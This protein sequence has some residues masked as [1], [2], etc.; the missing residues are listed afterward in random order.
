MAFATFVQRL[1]RGSTDEGPLNGFVAGVI[2]RRQTHKEDDTSLQCMVRTIALLLWALWVRERAAL[3]QSLLLNEAVKS[4][5]VTEQVAICALQLYVLAPF[6]NGSHDLVG[7]QLT[8]LEAAIAR[9]GHSNGATATTIA[10][11][12]SWGFTSDRLGA[13]HLKRLKAIRAALQSRRYVWHESEAPIEFDEL[14]RLVELRRYE[15]TR[16]VR[17]ALGQSDDHSPLRS[18]DARRGWTRATEVDTLVTCCADADFQRLAWSLLDKRFIVRPQTHD[19]TPQQLQRALHAR[20]STIEGQVSRH[21]VLMLLQTQRLELEQQV[22]RLTGAV[23]DAL[24]VNHQPPPQVEVAETQTELVSADK[25][26]DTG[27]A[28]SSGRRQY[29][30]RDLQVDPLETTTKPAPSAV[31]RK[32]ASSAKVLKLLQL[33]KQQSQSTE[34][35]KRHQSVMIPP[36]DARVDVDDTKASQQELGISRRQHSERVLP[37]RYDAVEASSSSTMRLLSTSTTRTVSMQPRAFLNEARQARNGDRFQ[38]KALHQAEVSLTSASTQCTE[39]RTMSA[40]TEIASVPTPSTSAEGT[41]Q[42]IEHAPVASQTTETNEAAVQCG[43]TEQVKRSTSTPA[44][45]ASILQRFPVV[46]DLSAPS[47]KPYVHVAKLEQ[48]PPRDRPV[49]RVIT[50][51]NVAEP[52]DTDVKSTDSLAPV[53]MVTHDD[54]EAIDTTAKVDDE[55]RQ[56]LRRTYQSH[57]APIKVTTRRAT[58]TNGDAGKSSSLSSLR[59]DMEQMKRKLV[60][61]ESCAQ[62]IEDDFKHSQQVGLSV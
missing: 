12:I 15:M 52:I 16:L 9:L 7:L 25:P 60:A 44:A 11:V 47:R 32:S 56:Q 34:T 62:E 10:L 33:R 54:A 36:P 42:R 13:R 30:I 3:C 48:T 2:P 57:Y 27:M 58:T 46:V 8:L 21:E 53:E 14:E 20:S 18:P 1:L 55:R 19:T 22:R 35:L 59:A 24:Q 28:K 41:A 51:S 5:E 39:M 43:F 4:E 49:E 31:L 23:N 50:S 61:L 17:A 40:Q 26:A 6:R 38:Q 29:R 37:L 45:T